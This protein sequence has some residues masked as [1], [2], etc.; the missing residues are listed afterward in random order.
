[1]VNKYIYK[2]KYIKW[3]VEC[4]E[5]GK[6]GKVEKRKSGSYAIEVN[7]CFYPLGNQKA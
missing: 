7:R 3:N 6:V 4:G 5:G 1:M 2:V